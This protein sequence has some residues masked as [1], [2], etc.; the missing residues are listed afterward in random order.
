MSDKMTAEHAMKNLLR[1][2][3]KARHVHLTAHEISLMIDLAHIAGQALT[4][5]RV[6]E[7]WTERETSL[8]EFALRRALNAAYS[9]ANESAQKTSAG[10]YQE[11]ATVKLLNDAKDIESI[12]AKLR[13]SAPAPADEIATLPPRPSP[14]VATLNGYP[15]LQRYGIQWNGPASPI[16]TPMQ[17]GY[18]TPWHVADLLLAELRERVKELE[19]YNVGLAN[20]SHALQ[21]R[22]K[23]L[24][25]ER[26]N[27]L[28][29]ILDIAMVAGDGVPD[30]IDNE[31]HPYQSRALSMHIAE[32]ARLRGG[33][34]E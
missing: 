13:S 6:P 8:V 9:M 14:E 15:R 33:S 7:G 31:G 18:W 19:G 32:A 12:L 23:A 30:A 2:L 27:L 26:W 5:P 28:S 25:G 24:E 21:E 4:A 17:D 22:V 1:K 29:Q 20:E 10:M 34:D 11:G 16:S 3:W